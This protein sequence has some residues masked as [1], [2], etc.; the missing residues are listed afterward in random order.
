MDVWKISVLLHYRI[1]SILLLVSIPTH[2]ISIRFN[3]ILFF[4]IH[5]C[6]ANGFFLSGLLTRIFVKFVSIT[7]VLSVNGVIRLFDILLTFL[8]SYILHHKAPHY[9]IVLFIT[10]VPLYTKYCRQHVVLR[11]LHF[12]PKV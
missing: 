8:E 5:L 3:L 1:Y 4:H 9:A 7:Y 10:L 2:V 11:Q 6:L 12:P